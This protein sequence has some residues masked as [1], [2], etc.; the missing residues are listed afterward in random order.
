M[1]HPDDRVYLE[2]ILDAIAKIER[3]LSGMD[4]DTFDQDS[5]VQDGVIRQV[6]IVGEACR[7]LSASLRQRYSSI[8]WHD[9]TG[10]RNKLVHD[11]FGVDLDAVYDAASV[12]M[13]ALKHAIERVLRDL[14]PA[15]LGGQ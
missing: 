9:I 5:L 10:M 1:K 2:H 3:Y 6:Q 8:P 4:R 12:D 7:R 14:S 15:D 11:Y 13:P